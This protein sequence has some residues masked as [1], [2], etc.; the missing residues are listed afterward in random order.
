MPIWAMAKR[1]DMTS[2]GSDIIN[3][4]ADKTIVNQ[5][6]INKY[7]HI[8]IHLNVYERAEVKHLHHVIRQRFDSCL[9]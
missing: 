7:I 9:H 6:E 1:C 5:F 3:R 4:F 8:Y 2:P